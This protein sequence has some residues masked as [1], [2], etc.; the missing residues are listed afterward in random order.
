MVC[1]K[2]IEEWDHAKAKYADDMRRLG[3]MHQVFNKCTEKVV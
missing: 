1:S 2:N 3:Y